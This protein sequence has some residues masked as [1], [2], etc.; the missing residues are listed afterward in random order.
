MSRVLSV[1][2][3]LA[4]LG[5]G[6]AG[7]SWWQSAHSDDVTYG[8]ARDLVLAAASDQIKTLN[9]VDYREADEDLTQWQRV[10]TGNLLTQLTN[11]HD[12]DV[13]S[14][15]SQKTVSTA[16]IIDAAVSTLDSRAGTATVLVAVEVTIRQADGQPSVRKSRVDAVL[17]RT[18]DGWKTG[19]VQV[20]E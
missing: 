12:S 6:W 8:Q 18:E 2:A 1:I 20:I 3:L 10:T 15:K 7:W 11:Q 9:T 16:K 17:S 13:N 5:A 19:T 14:T 4:V